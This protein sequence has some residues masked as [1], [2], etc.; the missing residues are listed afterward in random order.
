MKKKL[1]LFLVMLFCMTVFAQEEK[2]TIAIYMAGEE[3]PG[4]AGVHSILGGEF[5]RII[6]ESERYTAVDRTEA[7]RKQLSNEHIFQ[8]SGAV[9]DEQ[10][11]SL[12]RQLGAQ[13]LCV[14]QL[15]P[16]KRSYYL[17]VRLIDVETA[18]IIRT[19]TAASSLKNTNEITRV[20]RN[21]AFELIETEKARE[22]RERKK[23]IFQYTAV[24]LDIL[25]AGAI[26]VGLVENSNV[27][28]SVNS[29]NYP[30]AEHAAW[31]RNAAYAAGAALIAGG[32]TIHI[33]F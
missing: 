15:N 4:V 29:G 5:A 12:G 19:A 17:D 11:K 13:Y 31:N 25:G 8:R 28:K 7:V 16:V 18:E 10:I 33:L 26:A 2:L 23:K 22:L 14:S 20:V 27:K 3:P 21:I 24:G 30:D 6:S 32:I 1:S 9:D